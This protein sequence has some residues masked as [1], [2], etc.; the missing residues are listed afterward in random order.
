MNKAMKPETK[1]SAPIEFPE[2]ERPAY[3]RK[4]S[5]PQPLVKARR[6]AF[7]RFGKTDLN[8]SRRFWSDFGLQVAE[9]TTT[10]L[11]MRAVD[12]APVALVATQTATPQFIGAAFEV[13]AD[14]NWQDLL[15]RTGGRKLEADEV[16]GGGLGIECIEPE[17]FA[18]WLIAP[19]RRVESE[20]LR[21]AMPAN[22]N[23]I[24][25]NSRVNVT[26]R[27]PIEPATVGRLG[28]YVLQSPNFEQMA[29]WYMTHLGLIPSD[30]QYLPDGS[31][32][33]AFFRLDLGDY[34]ADH[35]TVVIASGLKAGYEHSA[36]EVADLDAL[37]Q[38]QQ[39]M[40]AAGHKHFWGIGRHVLG[41]Q[42]FDY[43]SDH[44]NHQFEHY[45]DGDVFTAD[46]PTHYVAF[47]PGSIWAWGDDAPREIFPQKSLGM[48]WRAIQLVRRGVYSLDKL[49]AMAAATDQPA[50][51]WL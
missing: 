30:V 42:L 37:G 5:R 32:L 17:G 6:L 8:K 21:L 48:L 19:Q 38:G 41:S 39:V 4:L 47:T 31:P 20:S 40:K 15:K 16:P 28:H 22:A 43:W 51:P 7:L 44:D 1:L 3:V 13:D 46:R 35:H 27:A 11:C 23:T 33:L 45:T 10:K 25:K 26:V 50:R 49:K 9:S 2:D 36:Y 29:Q 34:P 14:V 12:G 24:Q 18:V